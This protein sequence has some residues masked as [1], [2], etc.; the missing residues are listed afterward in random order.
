MAKGSA[1]GRL[2]SLN[3]ML[4]EDSLQ[5]ILDIARRHFPN[6]LILTD[7]AHKVLAITAEP[8]IEDAH[9]L[10]IVQQGSIPLDAAS[11]VRHGE[12]H[13]ESMR[14]KKPVLDALPQEGISMLRKTL[15][16]KNRIIGY[17][18]SPSYYGPY[19]GT[20]IE[21]F[22][23]VGFLCSMHMETHFQY[24]EM[25]ED[26]QEYFIADLLE[27]RLTDERIIR[28]RLAFF[29]LH[30]SD[31]L[32][33]ITILDDSHLPEHKVTSH[34]QLHGL[35]SRGFPGAKT[36]LYGEELKILASIPVGDDGASFFS[37]LA[38]IL[39][40]AGAVGGVSF[41][42][43]SVA[44]FAQANQQSVFTARLGMRTRP[45]IPLMYYD[46]FALFHVIELCAGHQD[47]F[48]FC[49]P[50]VEVLQ[51]Y[52][53]NNGTELLHTLDVYLLH[54]QNI[55]AAAQTLYLH[56]NTMAYRLAQIKELTGVDTSDPSDN[57]LLLFS[58]KIFEYYRLA[59]PEGL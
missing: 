32:R 4:Q 18:E 14:Q 45:G 50:A 47:P 10:E 46:D 8:E 9:W 39:R 22:D 53:R 48:A 20:D 44:Q 56:R 6:P 38:K 40:K 35:L 7:L 42:F 21:Y 12:V 23:S 49:H 52:D 27:G 34:A 11:G 25:P 31:D 43:R 58:F 5:A 17:L 33:V 28:E 59:K 54:G 29:N 55:T 37:P 57:L 24:S 1:A 2:S 41:P 30:L 3:R 51:D 19:S 13:L 15:F 26:L 16:V 36:F